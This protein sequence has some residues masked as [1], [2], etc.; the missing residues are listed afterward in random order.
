MYNIVVIQWIII[1][2]VSSFETYLQE[3]LL[4][5][6]DLH[7]LHFHTSFIRHLVYLNA[8]ASLIFALGYPSLCDY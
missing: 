8:F 5:P 7:L 3:R 1:D 4:C 2:V 6:T